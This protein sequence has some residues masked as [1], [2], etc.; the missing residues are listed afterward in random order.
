MANPF[1]VK[2]RGRV[3]PIGVGHA[4]RV[5]CRFTCGVAEKPLA[6]RDSDTARR[7]ATKD[8]V[9]AN[10]VD[11]AKEMPEQHEGSLP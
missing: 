7:E 8:A 1:D 5:S 4:S 9:Y 6:I 10:C 11:L 2:T 3:W